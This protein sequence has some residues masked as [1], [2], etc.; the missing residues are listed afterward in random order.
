MH[1][2]FIKIEE[3]ND[4]INQLIEHHP[5]AIF[6][7]NHDFQIE[8]FNQSY[9]K[10]VKRDKHE[11]LGK[12]FCET[13]GCTY[14]G[15]I[16]DNTSNFC[17][18]CRMRDLLS[19]SNV[20]EIDVIRDFKIHNKVKTKHLFFTTNR[21]VMNGKKLRLVEIEDRTLKH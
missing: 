21:V 6:V 11:I 16:I 1:L 15:N 18:R 4:L 5:N 9:K 12:E 17:K 3:A 19:G 20:S 10:L 7:A 14:R 13:L 8:Y 2:E